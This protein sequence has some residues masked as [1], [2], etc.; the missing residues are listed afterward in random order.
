MADLYGNRA[1]AVYL[2][3]L[4]EANEIV[5]SADGLAIGPC[6]CRAVFK[7]CDNPINT[8]I[9]VGLSRNIFIAERPH[10]YREITSEEAKAVLEQCHLNGL[11]HTII[12]CQKDFYSICNYCS[13]CCVPFRLSKHY[14]IGKTLV[15][16]ENIVE[17]LKVH[18]LS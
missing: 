11:I 13:C 2:L 12:K 1:S 15:R 5:E 17:E 4:Q 18:Q 8:E 3:T 6:T 7:N 10:D 16:K 9:I 14:G